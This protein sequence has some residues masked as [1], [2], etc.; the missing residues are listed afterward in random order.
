M[1]L[2]Y[3]RAFTLP[4]SQCL[5]LSDQRFAFLESQPES[6]RFASSKRR[7]F[8]GSLELDLLPLVGLWGPRRCSRA[9]AAPA[10]TKQN[11]PTVKVTR[12]RIRTPPA[13]ATAG[14]HQ[15]AKN[16]PDSRVRWSSA[17]NRPNT[18]PASD[19]RSSK[20]PTS[21]SKT[22]TTVNRELTPSYT[23]GR[24]TNFHKRYFFGAALEA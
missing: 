1:S 19:K 3:S 5:A 16:A 2:R 18:T 8:S 12:S 4:E 14:T 22:L 11:T 21:S 24:H 10:A 7:C 9:N 15:R 13:A 6:R 23:T 20:A 17:M